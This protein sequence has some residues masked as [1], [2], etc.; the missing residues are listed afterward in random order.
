[1]RTQATF[2]SLVFSLAFFGATACA[3]VPE[4][5]HI[6]PSQGAVTQEVRLHL[7]GSD[8]ASIV[9]AGLVGPGLRFALRLGDVQ[10]SGKQRLATVPAGLSAG[11]YDLVVSTEAG[12]VQTLAAAYTAVD[13]QL[14]LVVLDVGQ[15]SALLA[16][17]SDGSSLLFDGGKRGRAASVLRPALAR[18]A[19]DRLDAVVAS[20]FDEDHIG[21]LVDLLRGADNV[22]GNTD[23]PVLPL[24]LWDNGLVDDCDTQICAD[25]QTAARGRAKTIALD[26]R[27]VLG[28]AEAH[29]VAVAGNLEGG[30]SLEPEDSNAASVGLLISLGEHSL[31][32]SGD[33]PGGGLGTQDLETPLAQALGRVDLWVLNHHGSAG[34][35]AQSALNVLQPQAALIS[36]GEDN[37]YCH[38]ANLVMQRLHAMQIPVFLTEAGIGANNS[39]CEATDLSGQTQVVG[40]IVV[41][42]DASGEIKINDQPLP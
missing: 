13:A 9:E 33:L 6:D 32:V 37:A 36:V 21:G 40:D 10:D 27:F 16:I 42:I 23:D 5:D 41:D 2:F 17:G 26:Q 29:C 35:T 30:V 24:G 8:L 19:A 4:L 38:P 34:S 3:P 18:Y 28:E 1:M 14:R 31:L 11:I 25:Y 7:Y 15:G 39:N 12:V 22:S 20:H